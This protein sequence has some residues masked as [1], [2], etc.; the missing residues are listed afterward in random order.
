[1]IIAVVAGP[2]TQKRT[3]HIPPRWTHFCPRGCSV[4]RFWLHDLFLRALRLVQIP[5][6]G[7]GKESAS[8]CVCVVVA[9]P[10]IHG[11]KE[12]GWSGEKAKKKT[13]PCWTGR[14]ISIYFFYV[15]GLSRGAGA[16]L[17]AREW[18]R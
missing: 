17:P 11:P 5:R 3:S 15:L 2:R 9:D 4:S 13:S 6:H 8:A 16:A 12:M 10:S 7:I 1:M 18:H 14:L